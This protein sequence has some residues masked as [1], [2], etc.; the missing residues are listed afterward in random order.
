MRNGSIALRPADSSHVRCSLLYSAVDFVVGLLITVGASLTTALALNITKLDLSRQ[1]SIPAAQR[2][3]DYFRPFWI[4]VSTSLGTLSIPDYPLTKSCLPREQGLVLYIASQVVGSTLALSFLPAQYVAPLSSSSLIFNFI[5]AYLLVGTP[6]S[7]LDIIGTILG[8]IGVIGVVVFGNQKR[9]SDF[10][11]G[12][13]LSLSTL[14]VLW[15]RSEWIVYFV[16][17]EVTSLFAWWIC[18]ICHEVC[19]ARI[20][21]ERG[22]ADRDGSGIEAMVGRGG[23]RRVANPYEGQGFM[24]T[25][26]STRDRLKVTRGKLRAIVK[27]SIERWSQSRPDASIRKLAGFCWAV[28][29]GML[30]GTT[31]IMAASGVKVSDIVRS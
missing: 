14:K 13:N 4:L 27:R 22:D 9:P 10:D 1:E 15:G 20:I 24:G 7:K 23:G 28:T 19:M 12:A 6:I 26:K 17:L 5:F 3:P 2:K 25:L 16:C 21:D 18:G 8:V 11:T 29:G 31:V 30:S